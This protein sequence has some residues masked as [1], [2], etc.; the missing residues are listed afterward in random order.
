MN[1]SNT[2][3]AELSLRE[4]TA[5][6]TEAVSGGFLPLAIMAFAIGFDAGF[7]GVMAFSDLD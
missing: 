4:L 5:D 1:S 3:I 7:I 6:E 2:E